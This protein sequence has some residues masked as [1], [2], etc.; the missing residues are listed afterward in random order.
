MSYYSLRGTSCY[1]QTTA[2][3]SSHKFL[4]VD[5]KIYNQMYYNL[6][7][8]PSSE[9]IQI[10]L[11]KYGHKHPNVIKTFFGKKFDDNFP[12]YKYHF[13]PSNTDPDH[14]HAPNHSHQSSREQHNNLFCKNC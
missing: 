12:H 11:K 8:C 1:P 5:A 9:Y 2:Y 6:Y 3:T 13:D 14:N 7:Q 10:P 4:P